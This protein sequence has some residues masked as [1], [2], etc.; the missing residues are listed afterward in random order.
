MGFTPAREANAASLPTLPSWDRAA[1]HFAALIALT[2]VSS[3]KGADS[4]ALTNSSSWF[5]PRTRALRALTDRAGLCSWIPAPSP[6]SSRLGGPRHAGRDSAASPPAETESKARSGGQGHGRR[7]PVPARVTKEQ[8][9]D[10]SRPARRGG[11]SSDQA[12]EVGRRGAGRTPRWT[13]RSK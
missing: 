4:L 6:D 5:S 12:T 9:C 13:D 3:S 10:G 8:H 1:R 2:P 7:R 11:Q